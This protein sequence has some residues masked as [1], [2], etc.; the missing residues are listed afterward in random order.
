MENINTS[1][2][3]ETVKNAVNGSA[4]NGPFYGN[5]NAQQVNGQIVFPQAAAVPMDTGSAANFKKYGMI[6]VIFAILYA[7]CLYKNWAG[8]TYPF[9]MAGTLILINALRLKD[10][11]SI[12]KRKGR[13]S[14]LNIFY[15][16]SL[17]L[18][19][20]TKCVFSSGTILLLS[21]IAIYLLLGSF[22]LQLYVDTTGWDIAGWL[23]GMCETAVKPFIHIVTPF[24]DYAAH[25]EEAIKKGESEGKKAF[26]AVIIGVVIAIPLLAIVVSLLISADAVFK[27]FY[28]R[29]CETF[30][31]FKHI[32]D[33]FGIAFTI[34]V[35]FIVAYSVPMALSKEGVTAKRT[36]N[37]NVNPIIAITFST[38]IGLVY[39]LFCGIQIMYLF[40]GNM[41]LPADYTYAEYAHEGFYQLLAV[42][43]INL[44]LVSISN[45]LFAENKALKVILSIICLCTYVMIASA[46][47][48][49][50][51]YVQV[52]R[53]TFLR[54]FVL[55]FLAVLCLF[56]AF[57][58]V[59]LI[60]S[61]FPVFKACMIAITVAYI[62]F[63]FSNP[64]YQIA[65][66]DLSKDYDADTHDSAVN[67]VVYNSS[68]DGLPAIEKYDDVLVDYMQANRYYYEDEY[69]EKK[70]GLR[71][72]NYFANRGYSLFKSRTW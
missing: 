20:I 3:Q 14:V 51:L 18:L 37:G 9:Y 13:I 43:I 6:A 46:A 62:G 30:N 15:I 1:T 35:A 16:V 55:W 60:N 26:H 69:A 41:E 50:Y 4:Y 39:I 2:N 29:F 68:A 19:S 36:K 34:V 57:L 71:K 10:G 48:R 52:Y 22:V 56:V 58:M 11:E 53:L 70:A 47:M 59:S 42:C 63:A 17:M 45:R 38:I 25:R 49:M 27:D 28:I 54:L 23:L 24:R 31:I 7:F 65:K 40:I 21:A 64:D 33:I 32:S 61:R 66:Y 12:L 5:S 44:V 72:Y 8:I 67:Y